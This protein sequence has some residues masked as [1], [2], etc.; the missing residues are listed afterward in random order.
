MAVKE[1]PGD[2]TI[3]LGRGGAPGG[4]M[5]GYTV[6]ANGDV[7]QW[8]GRYPGENVQ[9]T[10]SMPEE[11]VN[12]LWAQISD[13][14]YFDMYEQDEGGTGLFMSVLADGKTHRVSWAGGPGQLADPSAVQGL[15]DSCEASVLQSL[16]QK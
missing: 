1:V 2:L 16:S 15:Y 11:E 8:E 14:G 9:R 7:T 6:Q 12:T 10:G 5:F 13:A 4:R 3:T